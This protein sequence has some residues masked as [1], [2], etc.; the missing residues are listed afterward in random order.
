MIC[1]SA[2][3]SAHNS[4]VVCV[5]GAETLTLLL[6]AYPQFQPRSAFELLAV[7]EANK[8]TPVSPRLR[9]GVVE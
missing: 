3:V 1:H 9:E 7:V 2:R 6:N 8:K 4:P 5:R